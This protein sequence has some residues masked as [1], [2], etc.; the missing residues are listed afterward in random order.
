[1]TDFVVSLPGTFKQEVTEAARTQLLSALHGNDPQEVGTDPQDLDLL[2]L[3][4]GGSTFTLRLE[5]TAEDSRAAEHEALALA[6]RALAAAGFHEDT[7]LLGR[8]AITS[9][10]SAADQD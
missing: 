5:V 9:I 1:M 3:N 6:S 2:T 10:D 8:P 4:D 7:A